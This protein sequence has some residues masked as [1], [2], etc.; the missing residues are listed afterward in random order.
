MSSYRDFNSYDFST[1]ACARIQAICRTNLD[2]YKRE[3]WPVAFQDV[4][5]PGDWVRAKS[6]KI[7]TIVKLTWR[8]DG[9]LEVELHR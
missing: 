9:V 7:L 2:E 6:G 4:P 1:V 3:E 8:Y 5:T